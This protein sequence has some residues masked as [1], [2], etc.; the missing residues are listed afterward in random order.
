[1]SKPKNQADPVREKVR[2][3]A[4]GMIAREVLAVNA[5]LGQDHID[6]KCIDANY[7]HHPER[8]APAVERAITAAR[9]EGYQHIF[10]GYADCGTGG[11]LDRVCAAHGVERIAGPHC[12][13]FYMGN[14]AFEAA[15]DDMMTTFFITDFLARHFDAFLIRPLGLDRYPELRDTYFGHYERALYLAQT[16]DPALEDKARAA[17]ERLGLAFE[18]QLTG[19]GD[20]TA[21]LAPL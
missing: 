1:M 7:H 19:Y 10:I 13:S 3:I 18:R 15:G 14:A 11:D 9:Q 20:L 6:L 5:Q 8:I 12:F 17:A 4:C 2:V 16:D 21:A